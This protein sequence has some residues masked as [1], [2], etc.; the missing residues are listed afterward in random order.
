M[1]TADPE[2]KRKKAAGAGT[3]SSRRPAKTKQTSEPETG[4]GMPD[5]AAG[6][7]TDPSAGGTEPAGPPRSAPDRSAGGLSVAL[8]RLDLARGRII[9]ALR[10]ALSRLLP[11]ARTAATAGASRTILVARR[12]RAAMLPSVRAVPSAAAALAARLV[13]FARQKPKEFARLAAGVLGMTVVIAF[14]GV[15]VW[16]E[17][18]SA[19]VPSPPQVSVAPRT[20][21]VDREALL[22]VG[23]RARLAGDLL[24][25]KLIERADDASS[26][27]VSVW[28]K[29]PVV[30]QRGVALT[31]PNGSKLCELTYTGDLD[32]RA[33][34]QGTCRQ[35]V[36]P[37]GVDV[38]LSMEQTVRS[39]STA[40]F[41]GDALRV[42]VSIVSPGG[43]TI[44]GR[45]NEGPLETLEVGVPVVVYV[46]ADACSVTLTAARDGIGKLAAA[47]SGETGRSLAAEAELAAQLDPHRRT[48]LRAG[49]TA[50]FAADTIDVY[51]A[52]VE[53]RRESARL[54]IDGGVV[55]AVPLGGVEVLGTPAGPCAFAV[56]AIRDDVVELAAACF[57]RLAGPATI[58]RPGAAQDSARGLV[59]PG[60]PVSLLGDRI[61]IRLSMISPDGEAVRWSLNDAG[62][63]TTIIGE[64]ADVRVGDGTCSV[65]PLRAEEG[66]LR[67]K[68][69]CDPAA[70]QARPQ[71]TAAEDTVEVGTNEVVRLL[72]GKLKLGLSM[73]SPDGEAIRV[74]VND[75]ELRTIE[76]GAP[77]SIDYGDGLCSIEYV[78]RGDAGARVRAACDAAAL[79]SDVIVPERSERVSMGVNAERRLLD[80]R[81]S[82]RLSMISPD[83]EAIRFSANGGDL[84]TA[85]RN[86]AFRFASGEGI[87]E[88]V[89]LGREGE[90][91]LLNAGCD[92]AA[93][94]AEPF[95]PVRSERVEVGS[96]RRTATQSGRLELAVNMIAPDRRAL[97]LAVNGGG[98][99]TLERGRP[100]MAPVGTGRCQ[101]SFLAYRNGAASLETVCDQGAFERAPVPEDHSQELYLQYRTPVS[102]FDGRHRLELSMIAPRRDAVRLAVDG[103]LATLDLA[104]PLSL[105]VEGRT[106][107]L[108][109]T[110]ISEDDRVTVKVGCGAGLKDVIAA[111]P[112]PAERTLVATGETARV[113]KG[114]VSL[115]LE[116]IAPSRTGLRV[117]IDGAKVSSLDRGVSREIDV[118]GRTCR[119]DFMGLD[120]SGPVEK[121]IV[122]GSCE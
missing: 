75:A 117:S 30:L 8:A 36:R 3:G 46:G 87:C 74:A 66:A 12:A 64:P 9:A 93:I 19:G 102:L 72:G 47:C 77:L 22:A 118:A 82:V 98:L 20:V 113:L 34:V 28:D 76:R 109:L 71:I 42:E 107:A 44:R 88:L 110:G 61:R 89:F 50:S 56:K 6:T 23:E 13:A 96:G 14:L 16:R 58:A 49:E 119:L 52:S 39:G 31:V 41:A 67:V 10:P 112:I 63:R 122:E 33:I 25:V 79:A 111:G 121:A 78:A 65:L 80:G 120:R 60:S 70:L 69:T 73:I 85:E 90:R 4:T 27:R 18:Q 45:L 91:A 53:P 101:I 104:S 86:E 84:M 26:V 1:S 15:M 105:P 32:D 100:I 99:R 43:G 38:G 114:A 7:A 94:A 48:E 95:V 37:E 59:R 97:R 83:G 116:M 62:L 17:N 29:D 51:L 24:T 103:R 35:G 68:A 54:S 92:A 115:K 2:P 40:T 106:C 57:G 81:L 108:V 55:E 11:A 5:P 21:S